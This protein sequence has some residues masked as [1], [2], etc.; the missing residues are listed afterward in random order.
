MA[1]ISQ[2]EANVIMIIV[3]MSLLNCRGLGERTRFMGLV[4]AER[5]TLVEVPL[6]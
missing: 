5:Q 4:T 1:H 3:R 2:H 6:E